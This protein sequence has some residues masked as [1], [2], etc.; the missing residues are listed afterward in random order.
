[1]ANRHSVSHNAYDDAFRTI[2]G[3]CDDA[4]L[5]FVNHMFN[6]HYDRLAHITRL[7]NEHFIEHNGK[8]GE[9][10]VTDSHFE[11]S[12]NGEVKIYQIECES[13]GY[14]KTL[15][16]RFF[17][18]G[19]QTAIDNNTHTRDRIV[20]SMPRTG[21]LV[22]RSKGD[23]PQRV[24]FEIQTPGGDISYEVPVICMADYSLERIFAENL[25]FLLPFFVFNLEDRMDEFEK[26]ENARQEFVD[27]YR[28]IL[29]KLRDLDEAVLSLRSKGVI[30][31]QMEAVAMRMT[32]E[33]KEVRRKV[34]DLMGGKVVEMEWL[35]Q[36]DAAVAKGREEGREEGAAERQAMAKEIEQLRKENE[37]LK[38]MI[39][40]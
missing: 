26:D 16:V 23:P 27:I 30:I 25:Y 31:K 39:P 20:V 34:G 22:L 38:E 33:K 1:M 5:A 36:F 12:Q 9:K 17:Q 4:L 13:T 7:R 15:L 19:V 21:L 28:N 18:Y 14:S 11:I 32:K 10:R 37:R 8:A 40:G 2:E 24:T 35:K 3:Q 6:E 29:E